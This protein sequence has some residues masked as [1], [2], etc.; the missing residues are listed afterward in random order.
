MKRPG[1]NIE[2]LILVLL[3]LGVMLT[4]ATPG[5]GAEPAEKRIG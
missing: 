3:W 5:F 1:K 4:A 2:R